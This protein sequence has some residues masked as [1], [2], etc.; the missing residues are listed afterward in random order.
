MAGL[1]TSMTSISVRNW[2]RRG[3]VVLVGQGLLIDHGRR[4][5]DY[6]REPLHDLLNDG[7]LYLGEERVVWSQWPVLATDRDS[8]CMPSSRNSA[9]PHVVSGRSSSRYVPPRCGHR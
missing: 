9:R 4:V 5:P 3:H 6:I 1:V 2:V 7:H 8:D